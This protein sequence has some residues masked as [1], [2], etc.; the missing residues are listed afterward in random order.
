ML[1][2]ICPHCLSFE[3]QGVSSIHVSLRDC[4]WD[5]EQEFNCLNPKCHRSFVVVFK[6]HRSIPTE[7]SSVFEEEVR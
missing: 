4:N 6:A 5:A 7:N 1:K 2:I 3:N